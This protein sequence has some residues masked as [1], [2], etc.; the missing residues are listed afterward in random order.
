MIVTTRVV[1]LR[2]SNRLSSTTTRIFFFPGLSKRQF[3]QLVGVAARAKKPNLVFV[4]VDQWRR[5]ALGF[6]NEDPVL[7]PNL[8][9]FAKT[10]AVFNHAVST[11]PVC[12]PDRAVLI[13]GNYPLTNGVLAGAFGMLGGLLELA[14]PLGAVL[15]AFLG[16]FTAAMAGTHRARA[17]VRELAVGFERPMMLAQIAGA[18]TEF[19]SLVD[20]CRDGHLAYRIRGD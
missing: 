10:S 19:V 18:G 15:G 16:G 8:D 17:E 1:S 3:T 5:Q 7:T 4:L 14:V 11:V 20:R 12:T 6:L 9:R 13:T 2:V